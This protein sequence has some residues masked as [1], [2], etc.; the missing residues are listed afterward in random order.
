[1]KCRY[2][3][4][5]VYSSYCNGEIKIMEYNAEKIIHVVQ[6]ETEF[7]LF[8]KK[9]KDSHEVVIPEHHSYHTCDFKKIRGC[10]Q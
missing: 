3:G 9:K 8:K 6:A 4:S 7:R 5:K 10:L 2:C 1:M